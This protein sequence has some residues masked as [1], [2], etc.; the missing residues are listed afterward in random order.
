[1]KAD[2][3]PGQVRA[4]GTGSAGQAG[5]VIRP[6]SECRVWHETTQATRARWQGDC[7]PLRREAG[8]EA[9]A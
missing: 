8:W 9:R 1:M 5:L 3:A 7:A 4:T 2:A 6:K